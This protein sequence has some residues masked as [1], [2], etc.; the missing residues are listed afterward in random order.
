MCPLGMDQT[1]R[2][3]QKWVLLSPDLGQRQGLIEGAVPY[4]HDNPANFMS[5][6][7]IWDA[8]QKLA[9]PSIDRN[10]FNDWNQDLI[11][12]SA[13]VSPVERMPAELLAMLLAQS[14]FTARDILAFGVCSKT[15]W[16]HVILHIHQDNRQSA[17]WADK[18]L[19]CA[20]TWLTDLPLVM[21]D[22]DPQLDE[23]E[24]HYRNHQGYWWCECPAR[25]WNW[26]AVNQYEHVAEKNCKQ[27]WI[28]AFDDAA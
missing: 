26:R 27:K 1:T 23:H 13:G 6:D 11:A 4:G 20:G 3:S 2:S 5:Q 28:G 9:K 18:P 15:L 12:S 7:L 8:F 14:S 22:R 16:Q 19:L 24:Q 25:G 21:Y 17:S 10:A